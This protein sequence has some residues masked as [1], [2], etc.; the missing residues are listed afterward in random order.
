MQVTNASY[1]EEIA[2]ENSRSVVKLSYAGLAPQGD[3]DDEDEELR[4]ED[5]TTVL[6]ALTP[7]KVFFCFFHGGLVSYTVSRLNMPHLTLPSVAMKAL[8]SKTLERSAIW[9]LSPIWLLTSY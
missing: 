7:G 1:G 4:L 3:D 6:C 2:D 8:S 9:L 5:V